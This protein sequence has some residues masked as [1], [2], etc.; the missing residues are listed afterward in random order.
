MIRD[1]PGEDIAEREKGEGPG[2]DAPRHEGETDPFDYFAEIV[3]IAH[4]AEHAASGNLVARLAVAAERSDNRVR[5]DIEGESPEEEREAQGSAQVEHVDEIGLAFHEQVLAD[6][7]AV[8]D[9]EEQSQGGQDDGEGG[10]R[11]PLQAR[12]NVA[13]IEIMHLPE[14]E[15]ED[16]PRGPVSREE[17]ERR[18]RENGGRLHEDPRRLRV[19]PRSPS[20][21]RMLPVRSAHEQESRQGADARERLRGDE[22]IKYVLAHDPLV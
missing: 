7:D 15:G 9:V 16:R 5:A 14:A 1:G 18:G 8:V 3:G 13:A 17:K 22:T 6:D 4:Q 20:G 19:H 12:K 21:P 11:S 10:L 2:R